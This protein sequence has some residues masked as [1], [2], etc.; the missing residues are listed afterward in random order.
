VGRGPSDSK[1]DFEINI[2]SK[3]VGVTIAVGGKRRNTFDPADVARSNV[4]DPVSYTMI[5]DIVKAR[6][7]FGL[8]LPALQFSFSLKKSILSM[9]MFLR[10]LNAVA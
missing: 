3:I 2:S 7:A 5:L 10:F 9:N 4:I 8:H 1:V 6:N